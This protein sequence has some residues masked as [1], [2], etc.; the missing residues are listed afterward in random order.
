MAGRGKRRARGAALAAMLLSAA[1]FANLATLS[2][3]P[4]AGAAAVAPQPGAYRVIVHPANPVRS[5]SRSFLRGVYLKKTTAWGNGEVVR[6]VGLSRRFVARDRFT[7]EV[8][9]KTPAQLRAYWNQQIFSG[10][11]APPPELDSEDAVI[12]HV[13]RNRG[14]VGYLPATAD[15]AAAAV[16][17][18]Q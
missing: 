18:V 14:A 4:A 13:L 2:A 12:S 9:N 11:G 15:P 8:L 6:P 7:R 10:K 5:V 16:V 3:R 1:A 17:H